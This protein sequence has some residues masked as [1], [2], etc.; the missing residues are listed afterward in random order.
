MSK[1]Q[2]QV[3]RIVAAARSYRGITQI[4][5]LAPSVVDG[6]EPIT[7]VAA[8]L[9]DAEQ[10]GYSFECLGRRDRCKV[11]RLCG[12]PDVERTA[13]NPPDPPANAPQGVGATDTRT[14]VG[15]KAPGV[16]GGSGLTT[17]REPASGSLDTGVEWTTD[18]P[19][20]ILVEGGERCSRVP[21]DGPLSAGVEGDGGDSSPDGGRPLVDSQPSTVEA[22]HPAVALSAG[23]LSDMEPER[24]GHYEEAA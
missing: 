15:S 20:P 7:R 2:T 9:W 12:E 1:H 11:W 21:V 18:S 3:E 16:S 22:G 5:F 19:P 6:K 13:S 23:R 24:V 8:R 14:R 17:R 10:E 4:D